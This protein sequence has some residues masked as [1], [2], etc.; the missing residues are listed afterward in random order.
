MFAKKRNDS[1]FS[2]SGDILSIQYYTEWSS[3]H[4]NL[5][6]QSDHFGNGSLLSIEGW[7]IEYIDVHHES[8]YEFHSYLPDDS[9]NDTWTTHTH[10]IV[11]LKEL[12]MV[13]S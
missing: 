9:R 11:I 12:E 3:V 13:T 7:N 8:Q 2:V 10:I 1:C 4:F 6:I 5:E